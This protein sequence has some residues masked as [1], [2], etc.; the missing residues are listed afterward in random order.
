MDFGKRADRMHALC[1]CTG[2]V[3]R[4]SWSTVDAMNVTRR[5]VQ[6]EELKLAVA[7]LERA[8]D[9]APVYDTPSRLL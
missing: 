3:G 9:G 7:V 4:G 6:R 1:R 2:L 5:D 8:G